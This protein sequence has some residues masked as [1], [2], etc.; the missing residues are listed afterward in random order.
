MGLYR[1]GRGRCFDVI[2]IS[3]TGYIAAKAVLRRLMNDVL[4]YRCGAPASEESEFCPQCRTRLTNRNRG[5]DLLMIF[6]SISL[7]LT[8]LVLGVGGACL[9]ILAGD[10][11]AG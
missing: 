10:P 7:I 2:R 5:A 4:C 1:D 3:A 8:T 6:G 9:I 11:L